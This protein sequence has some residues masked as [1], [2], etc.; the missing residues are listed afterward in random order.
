MQPDVTFQ[1]GRVVISVPLDREIGEVVK[2]ATRVCNV[3]YSD[4][5]WDELNRAIGELI[6][7]LTKLGVNFNNPRIG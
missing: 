1:D 5:E 7:A 6:D 4:A 3:R 2:A